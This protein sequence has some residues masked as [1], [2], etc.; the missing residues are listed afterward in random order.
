VI[1]IYVVYPAAP[2]FPGAYVV[3]RLFGSMS[4]LADSRG[5]WMEYNR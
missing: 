4:A 5:E 3:S 1:L 2:C